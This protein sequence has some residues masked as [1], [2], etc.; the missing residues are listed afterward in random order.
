MALGVIL[1]IYRISGG[2]EFEMFIFNRLLLIVWYECDEGFYDC[3]SCEGQGLCTRH[4]VVPPSGNGYCDF[5]G[6]LVCNQGNK[7]LLIVM[8]C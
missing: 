1:K 4:C 5:Y 2:Y 6:N 7:C 3:E 8:R